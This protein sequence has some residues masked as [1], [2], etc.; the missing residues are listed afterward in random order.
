MGNNG[1]RLTLDDPKK[2]RRPTKLGGGAVDNSAVYG[3]DGNPINSMGSNVG[4]R[5][6]Q[7]GR[8]FN[9]GGNGGSNNSALGW[10]SSGNGTLRSPALSN[11]SSGRFG[12]DDGMAAMNAAVAA[13]NGFGMGMPSPGLLNAAAL[14]QAAGLNNMGMGG[15]LTP[16]QMNMLAGM[17]MLTPEALLAAQ[18]AAV[19]AGGFMQPG[20]GVGPFGM[21]GMNMNS[22]LAGGRNGVRGT[23][24][25]GG[26]SVGGGN[27]TRSNNGRDGGAGKSDKAGGDEEVDPALL[28]DVPGWLRSLRLHKYTPNFE[29]MTWREMVVMDEAALEA[30][31]VAALGARR[32]MLKTFEAVR[33]KMGVE[34]P[35]GSGDSGSATTSG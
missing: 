33:N 22:S 24:R 4:Q 14:Q 18:M 6:G 27:G 13:A 17:N 9:G 28:N 26:S 8:N 2:F 3:D 5:G 11:V 23:S 34:M 30:K 29:T 25:T 31:G 20:M 1:S 19:G 21:P 16:L 12:S 15:Q 7:T 10:N 32:K 35:E